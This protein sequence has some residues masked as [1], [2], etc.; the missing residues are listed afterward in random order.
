[1]DIDRMATASSRVTARIEGPV[2]TVTINAPARRNCIDL[3]GWRAFPALFDAIDARRDIRVIVLTGEGTEAFSAG[4]DIAEFETERATAAGSRAYEVA[5][6][7]AFDAVAGCS[8]P[9]IAAIRGFCFG[10]GVGLAASTDIR[11]AAE[12]A[13]FSVPAARL[14][15]GYPPQALGSLVSLMGPEAVK[16]LFFAAG[17]LTAGEA[18]ALGLVGEVV[19]AAALAGRVAALAADIAAGAPLTIAAAKRAIDAAA[20]TGRILSRAD[21]QALAD[22]CFASADYAEGRAAF[23]QKRKPHFRGE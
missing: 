12:D 3:A 9:V 15:V 2:A 14:G 18:L 13:A 20:G 6:V 8:K 16:R 23:R 1:M 11:I 7:A 22:A 10:A 17:R 5:N 21:L 4:A 19:P